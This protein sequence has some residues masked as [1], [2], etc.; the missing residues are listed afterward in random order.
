M[1]VEPIGG[2][3]LQ[4]RRAGGFSDRKTSSNKIRIASIAQSHIDAFIKSLFDIYRSSEDTPAIQTSSEVASTELAICDAVEIALRRKRN[5]RTPFSRLDTDV[6]HSIFGMA[7]DLDRIHDL[8]F[9]LVCLDD[10]RRRI[11]RMRQVSTMWNGFLLSSPRYWQVIDIKS[12]PPTIA[13]ALKRSKSSPLCVYCRRDFIR[14]APDQIGLELVWS[15]PRVQTLR[16]DEPSAYNLCRLLLRTRAFSLKTLQL[17]GPPHQ[18]LAIEP[19]RE[20]SMP[21]R[22]RH[23]AAVGWQPPSGAAWLMDL[24]ELVL[25]NISQIDAEIFL[26]LRACGSLERLEIHCSGGSDWEALSRGPSTVTLPCLR[27]MDLIFQSDESATN[28]LRRLVTPQLLRGSLD[29][30]VSTLE[31][32]RAD[33]CRFMSQGKGC[34]RY[35]SSANIRIEDASSDCTRVVYETENRRFAF[36]VFRRENDGHALHDLVQEFQALLKEPALTVTNDDS[37]DTA[38]LFLRSLADQNVRNIDVHLNEGEADRLLAALGAPSDLTDVLVTNTTTDQ[39]FE[40]LKS[41]A[42]HDGYL[43]LDRLTELVE[44]RQRQL[45]SKSKRFVEEVKLVDC[46]VRGMGSKA[47][48]DR[49]KAIGVTLQDVRSVDP[50]DL[51]W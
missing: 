42:I 40:S 22:I 31:T 27:A 7:L 28:L 47:A 12:P 29:V 1:H 46:Y 36:M 10:H 16:S 30:G 21:S 14:P 5:E 17:I 51:W 11:N 34:L 49:L 8:N 6:V 37:S 4:D 38:W 26:V 24:Q 2:V 33:Y 13:A 45:Q 39:S 48:S 19:L 41:I 18:Q 3:C 15:A 20:L 25:D 44:T 43:E 9:P 35:P 50:E 32:H 23:L